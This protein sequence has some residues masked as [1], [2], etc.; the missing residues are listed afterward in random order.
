VA[1]V[2]GAAYGQ[3]RAVHENGEAAAVRRI[4]SILVAVFDRLP[5]AASGADRCVAMRIRRQLP[6]D[7]LLEEIHGSRLADPN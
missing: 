6:D 3:V 5:A 7:K 2:T 1:G 4:V